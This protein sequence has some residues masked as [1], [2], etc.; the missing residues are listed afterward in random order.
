MALKILDTIVPKEGMDFPVARAEDI[1]GGLHCVSSIEERDSILTS[2]KKKA[3]M[4]VYVAGQD[5]QRGKTY[6]L[7]DDMTEFIDFYGKLDTDQYEEI[8]E[9]IEGKLE[10]NKVTEEEN[11]FIVLELL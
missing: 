7:N 4:F 6:Q 1:Q 10:A 8:L 5:G 3:G 9:Y 11:G 2:S